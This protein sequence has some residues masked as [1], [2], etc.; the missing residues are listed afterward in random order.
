MPAL[1]TYGYLFSKIIDQTFEKEAGKG[2]ANQP[3]PK[4]MLITFRTHTDTQREEGYRWVEFLLW[5]PN[6]YVQVWSRDY[7]D[8]A[9]VEDG[10]RTTDDYSKGSDDWVLLANHDSCWRDAVD[11]FLRERGDRIYSFNP[12]G[13]WYKIQE[14]P[15]DLPKSERRF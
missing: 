10:E 4:S 3:S 2:Q 13:G 8:V 7:W 14:P 15:K 1:G 9:P 6:N 12:P 11:K 5:A